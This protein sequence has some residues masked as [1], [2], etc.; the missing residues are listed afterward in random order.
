[1]SESFTLEDVAQ[2]STTVGANN[3]R[4]L[5]PEGAIGM[6]DDSSRNLLKKSGPPTPRTEFG[7]V[8]VEWSIATGAVIDSLF[9]CML[10]VFARSCHFG[11]L[12]SEHTELFRR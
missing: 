9:R 5:H 11:P 3:L 4:P 7:I 12:L 10:V 8:L 1:M 2:M 6:S